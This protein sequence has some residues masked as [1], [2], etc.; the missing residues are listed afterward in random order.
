MSHQS[1]EG[2]ALGQ[3]DQGAEV[4][5]AVPRCS[6]HVPTEEHCQHRANADPAH[7]LFRRF[8]DR[9][10]EEVVHLLQIRA[11]GGDRGLIPA[12][13][14]LQIGIH[15]K[16]VLKGLQARRAEG[17]HGVGHRGHRIFHTC[18]NC[19]Y[20]IR[21]FGNSV[22][23]SFS[24]PRCKASQ[25]IFRRTLRGLQQRVADC[26]ADVGHEF[27][28][29]REN[30]R[31]RSFHLRLLLGQ[32]LFGDLVPKG[33]R[34]QEPDARPHV[35]CVVENEPPPQEQRGAQEFVVP[36]ERVQHG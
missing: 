21:R 7:G 2:G 29:A 10:I 16:D 35:A 32:G 23:H 4:E 33:E 11:R 15:L 20:A 9:P 8:E 12:D 19:E 26:I 34:D 36:R 30:P 28:G 14:V 31:F 18:S 1:L 6:A 5:E 25:S 13:R 24:Q 17:A 3:D 22:H 27:E